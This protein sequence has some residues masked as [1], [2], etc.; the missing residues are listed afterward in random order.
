MLRIM[1]LRVLTVRASFL[2]ARLV[3]A[4]CNS[5]GANLAACCSSG[6]SGRRSFTRCGSVSKLWLRIFGAIFAFVCLWVSAKGHSHGKD[7]TICHGA[8]STSLIMSAQIAI[9]EDM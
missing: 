5:Y 9:K 7:I 4:L 1:S 8:A 6:F 3:K 2:T